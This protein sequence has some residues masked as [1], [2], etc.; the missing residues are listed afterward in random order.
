MA[1]Y[2]C[3]LLF[4]GQGSQ[5]V[6][7]GRQLNDSFPEA[8][9]LFREADDALGYSLSSICF[10]G[11]EEKLKLTENTQPAI[12]TVSVAAY[13]LF[14]ETTS[15]VPSCSTGHSL[16]EYSALVAAGSIAFS[17]AVRAVHFRGKFMQEAVPV[18]AGSMAAVLGAEDQVV[19][20]ACAA[21]D[22]SLGVVSPANF[23]SPGQIVISGN[24]EAVNAA[25]DSLKA[26]GIRK[27]VMLPVS[28]PFHCR[29]MKPAADR[30]REVIAGITVEL[31]HW[32]VL[33]N[34]S[35]KPYSS[36]EEIRNL[37]VEQVMKPVRWT[38]CMR[39]MQQAGVTDF[40]E[41]GPGKVLSGL[42]KRIEKECVATSVETPE[43]I[44]M[45]IK[46]RKEE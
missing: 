30:L 10:N 3:G 39:F 7:M 2:G 9:K 25:A 40:I 45:Y 34:V 29:L 6:G 13:R 38:D 42:V 22:S 14:A 19:L 1:S 43:E 41:I 24:T 8:K 27:I 15:I 23:N 28:A 21:V 37:L 46:S 16:G 26:K 18:G 11:P 31:P 44:E 33:S 36:V 4:P 12:L 20:D 17:D 35:G 32:K 5:Y